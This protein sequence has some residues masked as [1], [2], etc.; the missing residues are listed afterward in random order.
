MRVLKIVG[1]GSGQ[2]YPVYRVG[3]LSSAS[4]SR[5]AEIARNSTCLLF[6]FGFKSVV[7]RN[8]RSTSYLVFKEI[9]FVTSIDEVVHKFL[10][11]LFVTVIVG[12]YASKAKCKAICNGTFTVGGV[13]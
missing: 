13:A 2:T 4:P 7:T 12:A 5:N 8:V 10:T 11:A 6:R 3:P 9:K 1:T